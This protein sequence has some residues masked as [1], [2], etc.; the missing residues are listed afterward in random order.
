MSKVLHIL[1]IFL[2]L[3]ILTTCAKKEESGDSNMLRLHQHLHAVV[4]LMVLRI[5]LLHLQILNFL[6]LTENHIESV[7]HGVVL[8]HITL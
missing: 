2:V 8:F 7:K 3:L 6:S 1:L 5:V 4:E